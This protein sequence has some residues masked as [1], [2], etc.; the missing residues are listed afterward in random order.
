MSPVDDDLATPLRSMPDEQIAE[1]YEQLVMIGGAA[2]REGRREVAT[3]WATVVRSVQREQV[4]R[5]RTEAA[6]RDIV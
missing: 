1:L 5:L 2:K 6:D 4:R 3:F